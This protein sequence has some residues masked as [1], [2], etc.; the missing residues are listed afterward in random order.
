MDVAVGFGL[1]FFYSAV[2]DVVATM[3]SVLAMVAAAAD[4]AT[5]T[6]ITVNGLSFFS[7]S[8]AVVE[9]TV[10]AANFFTGARLRGAFLHR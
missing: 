7:F 3:V 10:S 1:L 2:V 5:I 8:S 4:V 9:T 6:A